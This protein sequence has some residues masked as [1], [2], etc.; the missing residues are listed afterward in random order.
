[1][2]PFLRGQFPIF[3][4]MYTDGVDVGQIGLGSGV[5][6]MAVSEVFLEA[7]R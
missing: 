6:I 4:F 5:A 1:M 2:S 3:L 7:K